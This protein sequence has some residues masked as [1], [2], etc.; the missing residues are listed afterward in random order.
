MGL[1]LLL[2][3]LVLVAGRRLLARPRFLLFRGHPKVRRAVLRLRGEDAEPGLSADV[4]DL[5]LHIQEQLASTRRAV[6]AAAGNSPLHTDPSELLERLQAAAAGLDSYLRM[7]EARARPQE[8]W[9]AFER[10][11]PLVAAARDL[12]WAATAAPGA[13][14]R[15]EVDALMRDVE[16]NVQWVQDGVDDLQELSPR[17]IVRDRYQTIRGA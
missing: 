15:G 12:R 14:S 13:T 1:L 5:R 9:S 7:L 3:G 10:T 11:G 17:D 4:L 8:V 2:I 6:A 16:R